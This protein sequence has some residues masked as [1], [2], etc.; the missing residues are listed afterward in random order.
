MT[1]F[2]KRYFYTNFAVIDNN[3]VLLRDAKERDTQIPCGRR[4]PPPPLNLVFLKR[5]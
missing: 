2:V 1:T 4:R 3:L 5:S